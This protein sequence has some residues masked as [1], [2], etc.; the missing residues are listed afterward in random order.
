MGSRGRRQRAAGLV[1]IGDVS[2]GLAVGVKN[3]WQ[4]YPSS[5]E[6]TGALTDAAQVHA[7]LWSPDAPGMDMRHYDTHGHGNVNTGGSYEDFEPAFATP[8][9]V[10]KT[11]ELMLFPTAST[12][13][14]AQTA[15]LAEVNSAPPLLT[16]TPDYLHSTGVFGIW[17]VQDRSTP[18]KKDVE[19]RLDAAIDYYQKRSTS[20]T[21][22]ASGISAMSATP[23]TRRGMNG[24]TTSAG[25]RGTTA[26]W[27]ACCGSG[28]A[29][30]APAGPIFSAWPRR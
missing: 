24:A 21:F 7:W 26:N 10:G 13:T 1:F 5:L 29:I 4:S 18:L 27:G 28:T 9:G 12:P 30:S 19:D 20:I 25:T 3:F 22:T 17:S 15:K 6:V 16:T 23:M 14:R 11:S 8:Y 2:G